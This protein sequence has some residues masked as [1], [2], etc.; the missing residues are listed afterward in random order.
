[1]TFPISHAS[2]PP[3]ALVGIGVLVGTFGG[4]FGVGGSFIAGPMLFAL[5]L[6]MNFVVGTDLA[7]LVGTGIVAAKRHRALGNVDVKLALLMTVGTLGGVELGARLVERLVH[8]H[9]ANGVLGLVSAL[10]F[11][12]VSLAVGLESAVAIAKGSRDD[13][14]DRSLAAR[15]SF[16]RLRPLVSFPVSGLPA[17]SVW[18]VIAVGFATGILSG[19]LGGGGGY[20]RMP[21]LVYLLGVPTHVAVGTDLFEVVLSAG[22]GTVSHSL[23]GNVDVVVALAL[24]V[25]G[26]LGARF[27]TWLVRFI[28]GPWLRL[29]F[30]PLPALGGALL[31]Y[32]LYHH[33]GH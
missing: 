9:A 21:M 5:G 27:G 8:R 1:M 16:L 10:V 12:G 29:A 28:R 2:L 11:F 3:L 15:W 32:T 18:L 20:L 25:G 23:K 24:D 13:R 4:L 33:G 6:P 19:L 30:A 17:I 7:S 26:V 22:Y 14:A 31:L